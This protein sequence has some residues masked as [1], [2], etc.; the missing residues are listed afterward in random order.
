[1][2]RFM[3]KYVRGI[4][5]RNENKYNNK[6]ITL[7]ILII[8]TIILIIIASVATFSGIS[9]IQESRENTQLSELRMV[10]QA[11]LENYTKYK[12]TQNEGYLVGTPITEYSKITEIINEVNA[13][14]T[15]SVNLKIEPKH[16]N[17]ITEGTYDKSYYYYELQQADLEKIGVNQEKDTYIVNYV[18]GEV[19]NKDLLATGNGTPLYTY[20]VEAP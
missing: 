8:T 17:G 9:A 14:A 1:M 19:I 4:Q 7:V 2:I 5:M 16:Y 18:T 15:K 3:K 10:Q 12:M 13:K 20:A 11:V 6:G